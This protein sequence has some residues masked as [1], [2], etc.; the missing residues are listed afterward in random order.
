MNARIIFQAHFLPPYQKENAQSY[1]QHCHGCG[2]GVTPVEVLVKGCD[3]TRVS[4]VHA[5]RCNDKKT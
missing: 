1:A 5:T 3:L 2:N 4:E